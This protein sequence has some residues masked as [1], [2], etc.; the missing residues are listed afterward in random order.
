M[1]LQVH[2]ELVFE[3]DADDVEKTAALVKEIME[4]AFKLDAVLAVDVR[5]GK[6]WDEMKKVE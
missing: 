6:N 1:I 4:G 3:C 5:A 2:D